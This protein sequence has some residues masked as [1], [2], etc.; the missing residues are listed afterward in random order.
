[1]YKSSII[2]TARNRRKT[3]QYFFKFEN[4]IIRILVW[5]E[6]TI[7]DPLKQPRIEKI[8]R[9]GFAVIVSAAPFTLAQWAAAESGWM[10]LTVALMPQSHL[11]IGQL[12]PR[13]H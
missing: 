6:N 9:S 10:T 11:E 3:L 8:E 12:M 2:K 5:G 7:M 1:M 4:I 13:S